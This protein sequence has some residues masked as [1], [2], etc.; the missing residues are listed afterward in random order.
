M[1]IWQLDLLTSIDGLQCE[2]AI[3]EKISE[4]VVKLEFEYCAYGLRTPWPVAR[5]ATLMLSNYPAIWQDSYVRNRYVEID[6][7]VR[8]AERSD[9]PFVWR[10]EMLAAAPSF[11]EEAQSVGLRVGWVQSCFDGV[12]KGGMLTVSRSA[13]PLSAAELAHKEQSLRF[14]V[15]VA[16]MRLSQLLLPSH[17]KQ[18]CGALTSREIEVLKWTAD[19]KTTGEI[20]DLLSVSD[21]T[22]KF[23]IRNVI[24]KLQ[25]ANKTA[26]AV[27]A[28][29]SGMLN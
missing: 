11:W 26:A 1:N 13:T 7:T 3:F 14:L 23:H 17:F 19:G 25:V 24:N 9:A 21:C 5:P 28:A 27:Y 15:A 4:A 29:M 12:A 8:H 10:Q 2:K 6:P 22:V 16:H 18:Q 20:S